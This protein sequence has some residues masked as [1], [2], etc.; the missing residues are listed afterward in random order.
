MIAILKRL[1][2][3]LKR[4]KSCLRGRKRKESSILLRNSNTNKKL[5]RVELNIEIRFSNMK[6]NW[7]RFKKM[8]IKTLMIRKSLREN[9]QLWLSTR[10][11]IK[12]ELKDFRKN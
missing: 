11:H 9:R 5:I 4:L 2:E 3:K 8:R 6:S 12:Q 1:T 10:R 7:R